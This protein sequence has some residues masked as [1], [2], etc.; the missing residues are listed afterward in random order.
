MTNFV[1]SHGLPLLFAVVMLESFG[2]PLPGE[3]A[4]IAFGVLA[5]QGRYPIE[6]VTGVAALAAIVGDNLGYWLIGRWGGR[7]LFRR[8]AWLSRYADRVLP[9]AERVLG[10]HGGKTVFFGRFVAVLRYTVAWVAG[11]ARMPWWRF[12]FWNAAGGIAWATTVGL[13]SYY[14]GK[15]AA[16]AIATYGLFAAAAIVAAA[17]IAWLALRLLGKRIEREL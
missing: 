6:V 14:L 15:K 17:I 8:W 1:T 7:N 9:T 16:D 2:I 12:L 4:L 13:V 11:L 10:R 5:A 3:T